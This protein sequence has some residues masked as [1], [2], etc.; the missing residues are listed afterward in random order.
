[1][2][3]SDALAH[4][5]FP[6]YESRLGGAVDDGNLTNNSLVLVSVLVLPDGKTPVS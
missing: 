1:M 5:Y 6:F 4:I 2:L 3:I